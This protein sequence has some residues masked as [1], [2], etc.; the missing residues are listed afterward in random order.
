MSNPKVVIL[1][2]KGSAPDGLG[3]ALTSV[4]LDCIV[5]ESITSARDP[6]CE[7]EDRLFLL[8]YG[9]LQEDGFLILKDL[10][11]YAEIHHLPLFVAGDE[12]ES[13]ETQL[14]KV[15]RLVSCLTPT[16]DVDSLARAVLNLWERYKKVVGSAQPDYEDQ[17]ST[18]TRST[19]R[20]PKR[21]P[22]YGLKSI[23]EEFF[24]QLEG[25]KLME[26]AIGGAF[27]THTVSPEPFL[28]ALA[29]WKPSLLE[30][31]EKAVR[32]ADS[33]VSGHILRVGYT[34]LRVLLAIGCDEDDVLA[35]TR[36]ALLHASAF[37]IKRRIAKLDYVT[38]F[39]PQTRLRIAAAFR[40]SA[41]KISSE[42]SMPRE[43]VIIATVSKLIASEEVNRESREYVMASAICFADALSRVGCGLGFF[44]PQRGYLIL[45]KCRDAE[46]PDLHPMILAAMIKFVAEAIIASPPRLAMPMKFIV[47]YNERRARGEVGDRIPGRGEEQIPIEKLTPGMRLSRPLKTFDGAELLEPDMRLDEDLIWRVWQLAAVRPLEQAMVICP[48]AEGSE[49]IEEDESAVEGERLL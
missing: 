16:V 29:S 44:N 4:N 36:A 1:S 32:G 8:Y 37:K 7:S 49:G 11:S 31:A 28:S 18:A 2:V 25:L 27:F 41:S 21:N 17:E 10:L 46:L 15:F 38:S 35:A 9:E 48:G 40:E 26:R 47:K 45:R 14:G 42:F 12:A 23:P 24:T 22:F 20:G 43:S 34:T 39:D 6:L 33:W 3:A 19:S 13:L 30:T 5:T